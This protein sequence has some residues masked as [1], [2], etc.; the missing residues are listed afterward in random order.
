MGPSLVRVLT[1]AAGVVATTLALQDHEGHGQVLGD[2]RFASARA[3]TATSP[4]SGPACSSPT[5]R[6][7]YSRS[8]AAG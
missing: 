1:I 3:A 8:P 2:V 4:F 7:G 5:Q 6:P